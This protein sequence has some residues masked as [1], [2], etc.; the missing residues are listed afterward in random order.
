MKVEINNQKALNS[1]LLLEIAK[2]KEVLQMLSYIKE[3]F[4]M[5]LYTQSDLDIF[6]SANMITEIEKQEIMSVL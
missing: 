4:V 3:Y 5:C 1:Q 2:L 6:V